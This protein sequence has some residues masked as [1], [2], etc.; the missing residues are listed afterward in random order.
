M[1]WTFG[2][3]TSNQARISNTV[4]AQAASTSTQL[5]TGWF[6]PTTLTSGGGLWANTNSSS[7]A[8][9]ATVSATSGEIDITVPTAATA[10]VF[11][12]SGLGMIVDEWRF[13]AVFGTFLSNGIEVIAVWTGTA[14]SPPVPVT[15]TTVVDPVNAFSVPNT[16][17]EIGN[18]GSSG[19]VAWV[20]D[21]AHVTVTAF[22]GTTATTH[23]FGIAG[24]GTASTDELK[25]IYE[26]M[27]APL[28]AGDF[29]AWFALG[30]GNGLARVVWLGEAYSPD[31]WL[32]YITSTATAI[33]FTAA[34]G[35]ASVA[36]APRPVYHGVYLP[37]RG[38]R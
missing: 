34:T 33:A 27:V 7:T 38:R 23:P 26:K 35:A 16:G 9:R 30:H 15:V 32:G 8:F 13:I 5:V 3:A 20:G 24:N 25:A 1:P 37:A 19:A 2:G 31:F 10:G 14:D 12:T 28:W 11:T 4:L 6:N 36:S 29:G 18:V 22:T 17:F 21:I